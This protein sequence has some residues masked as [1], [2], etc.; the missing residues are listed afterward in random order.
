M[1][2]ADDVR[3][4]TF[5]GDFYLVGGNVNSVV[6]KW[7]R[8]TGLFE[9]VQGFTT[10]QA[11]DFELMQIGGEQY[12]VASE[13]S[14]TTSRVY[15]W[16]GSAF[17]VYQT[18]TTST[19]LD[20][21]SERGARDTRAF[22]IGGV[23]YL[24]VATNQAA[25]PTLIFKWNTSTLQFDSFQSIA[26][27]AFGM[28]LEVQTLGASTYLV[29]TDLN[30]YVRLF[31]WNGT[32]F[33]TTATQTINTNGGQP[34]ETLAFDINGAHYLLTSRI[35]GT[36]SDLYLW[37]G[38]QYT[39]VQS[40]TGSYNRDWETFS[41]NGEQYFVAANYDF[42][43]PSYWASTGDYVK[44]YKFN[45][46]TGQL[47]AAMQTTQVL[48]PAKTRRS[49]SLQPASWPMTQA[50]AASPLCRPMQWTATARCMARWR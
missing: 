43:L 16:D 50:P 23:Q 45:T 35:V 37:N 4:F 3:S 18:L 6:E 21:S 40:I 12:M 44:F 2:G 14:N 42:S 20:T 38:T 32:N 39:S 13:L 27:G 29:S 47:D 19:S 24:A 17:Q 41:I 1:D 34:M 10:S 33:N 8:S 5:N 25:D 28:D 31:Q 30:G 9:Q 22:T 49:A 46:T 15:K 7:N 11:F 36:Q 48:A 26:E